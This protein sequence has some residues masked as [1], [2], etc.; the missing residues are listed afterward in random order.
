MN[1]HIHILLADDHQIVTDGIKS[2]LA[3]HPVYQIHDTALS[4]EEAWLKVSDP[5]NHFD[6]VITDISMLCMSGTELCKKIKSYD[7]SIKVMIL[8]MHNGLEYVK[9]A[10]ACG[11]DGYILKNCGRN[12]FIYAL[13]SLL[14]KGSYFTQE[15][16]PLLYKEVKTRNHSSECIKLS[17]RETEIMELILKEFT[18]KQ[19]AEKLFI[20][21][22]TVD[23]HRLSI[24][25]KTGSKS[26]VGLI[27]FAIKN[28]LMPV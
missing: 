3:Q 19:I 17:Q 1:E 12:E 22:Q 27:K 6:V 24:M 5:A 11:A 23:T 25:E 16:V 8:S 14:A 28:N 2:M 10:L 15:I 13:D 26:I 18:S 4:A 21:K 20:S 9:E 7:C